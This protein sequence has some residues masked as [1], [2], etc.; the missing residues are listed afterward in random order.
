[1]NDRLLVEAKRL[2]AETGRT[3]DAVVEDALRQSMGR[4]TRKIRSHAIRLPTFKG[5][6]MQPGVD[7]ADTASLLD[8]M[9][10]PVSLT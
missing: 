6:G 10:P 9:N 5:H 1:M 7:L 2:A 4:R 3:L 8:L